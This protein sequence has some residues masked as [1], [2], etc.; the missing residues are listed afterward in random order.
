MCLRASRQFILVWLFVLFDT[1]PIVIAR[2]RCG[3]SREAFGISLNISANFRC[4]R[5][6]HL[7]GYNVTKSKIVNAAHM[8][9][10]RSSDYCSRT[11]K[12]TNMLH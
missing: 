2:R 12:Y 10:I 5:I 7:R 8:R 4:M 9:N 3:L 11:G 1:F 6:A